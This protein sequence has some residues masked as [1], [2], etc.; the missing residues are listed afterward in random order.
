MVAAPFAADQLV[1]SLAAELGLGHVDADDLGPAFTPVVT[2]ILHFNLSRRSGIV[3]SV[4]LAQAELQ[5]QATRPGR[6]AV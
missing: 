3:V 6:Y 4:V 5:R 2:S 1:L